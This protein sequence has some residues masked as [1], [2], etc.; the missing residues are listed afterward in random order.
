M[1]GSRPRVTLACATC[2]VTGPGRA[3]LCWRCYA[4][5][6]HTSRVCA[7]CNQIRRH[8]AA[9][10]CARC[11]RLSRTR[12]QRCTACGEIRPVYFG[13]RCERCKQRARLHLGHCQRCGQQATLSGRYCRACLDRA[14]ERAGSCTDCL[15][16]IG[17]IGG[18]CRPCRLF[19]WKHELGDCP[20][21]G[22][23]V[24][25]GAAGRCRLCLA[26][27]RATGTIPSPQT[28]IQLFGL[29]HTPA[30]M[31]LSEPKLEPR[32]RRA[33]APIGQLRLRPAPAPPQHASPRPQR[34]SH[35]R[36]P[37]HVAPIGQPRRRAA[38][39]PPPQHASPRPQRRN[40]TRQPQHQQLESALIGYGQARG[41]STHHLQ[42]IRRSLAALFTTQ[43][44]LTPTA[45]LDADT[46]RQFLLQRRM[47]ALRLVEFLTD[48][49]LVVNNQHAILDRWLAGRLQPLPTQIR[50]EVHTW[51]EVLRGRGPRPARPRKP[52]TIQGYLRAL[53]PV[54]ADWSARY[55]SLRQV[56]SHDI[57]QQLQL[58]TGA[59]RKLVLAAMR[60]LFKT[61]KAQQLIFTNPTAGLEL[62]GEPPPP[63]LGLDPA[64]RA[65][66]LDQLHR[67]DE[68]VIVLLAGIHALRP[69]QIRVLALDDVDLGAGT[70][71]VGGRPRRLDGLT[72][73]EL[74]AWLEF[75]RARWP[76][77]ANPY[78][79][80]NQSTAGGLAPVTRNYVQEVFRNLGLT[81]GDLRVDRLLAEVQATGGD[82]LRLT[83]L[84][85]ISDTTAIRYCLEL[86]PLDQIAQSHPRREFIELGATDPPENLQ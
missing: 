41:W 4:R 12:Q 50:A 53:E 46:V 69:H 43:P 9:G 54:L 38:P 18:H 79:L 14:A 2:G 42:R 59:T 19:G 74:R 65:S 25:L 30:R 37:Q 10:L 49:G 45:P 22:R 55:Q 56:T 44:P 17:L 68:R 26:S 67:R 27:A 29:V 8:L 70:L 57:T 32:P 47:T 83:R 52:A 71:L 7:G 39:A 80:V 20:S 81:A 5:A 34:R 66:L 33:A 75:R 11:Y 60:S 58:F 13:D 82:P 23:H 76:T 40:R 85:G 21:C 35:A 78:L 77:S 24:P 64:R 86:G 1:T 61:L 15:C 31:R 73:T 6:V 36:Q 16:W 3:G 63:A 84:F 48:Q 62:R 72:L 51:I 28:G